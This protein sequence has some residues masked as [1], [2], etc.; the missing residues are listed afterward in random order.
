MKAF[1]NDI[2][3]F[4]KLGAQVLG[5]SGDSLETHKDFVK[6]LGLNFSLLV[7]D[8]TISKIYGS[9]RITYLIDSSGSIRYVH[10]GM[11]GNDKLIQEIGK[12]RS[13]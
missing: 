12:L 13:S 1:Q 10:K 5:V 4:E 3:R 8:G 6:K 2:E 9:G 7:D 11:P